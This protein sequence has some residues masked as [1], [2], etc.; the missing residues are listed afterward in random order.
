MDCELIILS[1]II[2]LK[3]LESIQNMMRLTFA[4]L[5]AATVSAGSGD[6]NYLDN[7]ENWGDVY[8]ICK[9]GD[10]QS[11]INLTTADVTVSSNMEINGY[12]YR[13][14]SLAVEGTDLKRSEGSVYVPMADGEFHL[15]FAD[16][17][18]SI[19]EVLQFHFHA[20]SE[21]EVNG[22]LYDLE[23]HFVHKYA[24]TELQL[25]GVIG[26][27]FDRSAGNYDN[28]F[29]TALWAEGENV[30]INVSSFFASVDFSRYWNYPGSLTTPPCTQ[31]IKWTVIEDVQPISD[32]QL[33]KFTDMWAGNEAW[34]EGKGNNRVVQDLKSRTLHYSGALSSL[35]FAAAAVTASLAVLAF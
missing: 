24:D 30:D 1:N 3:D 32:A 29:L 17:S 27:F 6:Y 34:S 26:I 14:F 28:D 13:D 22:S 2:I 21:H 12:G 18:K 31:G 16:G 9:D 20:P 4:A 10:Q 19:F 8:P 5:V 33:K 7:G 11:P 15:N 23:V 35:S 25:G